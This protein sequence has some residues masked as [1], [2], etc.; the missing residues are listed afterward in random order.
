MHFTPNA[1][2]HF[3]RWWKLFDGTMS[4]PIRQGKLFPSAQAPSKKFGKHCGTI[5]Y[6]F[7]LAPLFI[8]HTYRQEELSEWQNGSTTILG[9]KGK[10]GRFNADLHQ[11][12][13][14]EV[15][16]HKL[17]GE[18]KRV[19]HKHFNM[20]EMDLTGLDLRVISA[21]F[22]EHEKSDL[23]EQIQREHPH[24]TAEEGGETDAE[25][26]TEDIR[27]SLSEE[28]MDWVDLDDYRDPL[29][30]ILD[31]RDPAV[32]ILPFMASPRFT[33]YRDSDARYA[34]QDSPKQTD[35]PT[36]TETSHEDE[37]DPAE[38]GRPVTKFGTES[39]HTCLMGCATRKSQV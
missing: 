12:E 17:T 7:S 8:S 19:I 13:Q 31:D 26:F 22:K 3:S 24:F 38:K 27:P 29:C 34:Q 28:E 14:E 9:V 2:T 20:I 23:M 36:S 37:M 21:N 6:R 4:L 11:R 16:Q 35:S 32:K 30:A 10:I 15:I 1:M 39:S 33:Y 25:G 18:T 5:K